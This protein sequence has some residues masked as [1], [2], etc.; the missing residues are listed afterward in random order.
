MIKIIDPRKRCILGLIYFYIFTGMLMDI[1]HLPRTILY[2]GDLINL[3]LMLS[4]LKA[5]KIRKK[6]SYSLFFIIL[7]YIAV[8]IMG[9]IINFSSESIPMFIWGARNNF[10]FLIFMYACA[11]FLEKKDVDDVLNHIYIIFTINLVVYLVEWIVLG[12]NGDFLGGIFGIT[13]GCNGRLNLFL[14]VSCAYGMIQYFNKKCGLLLVGYI[15]AFSLFMAVFS[16]L[17]VFF[18]ELVIIM[19]IIMLGEGISMR[20]IL[21]AIGGVMALS[22]AISVLTTVIDYSRVTVD[23]GSN[24]FTVENIMR[25]LTKDSGYNGRG[26]DLNRFTAASQLK[27]R[28]FENDIVLHLFGIGLGK[29][30]YSSFSMF[31]SDFYRR[32]SELHYQWFQYAWIY[33]ETG[34]LGLISYLAIFMDSL[35][36]AFKIKDKADSCYKSMTLVACSMAILSLVYNISMRVESSGFL[37]FFLMAIPYIFFRDQELETQREV[38]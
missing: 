5:A 34:L 24:F 23:G 21:V 35:R 25:Y 6:Y 10:R 3:Y 31:V 11:L 9:S 28:F 12:V 22:F 29:G 1:F 32:Y 19:A 4:I 37:M 27:E 18:F 17:K 16:E 20:F 36:M 13:Q 2:I 38:E 26:T 30:D 8:T 15:I 7:I 33:L 14:C